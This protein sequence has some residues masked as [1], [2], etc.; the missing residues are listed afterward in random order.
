MNCDFYKDPRFLKMNKYFIFYFILNVI[1]MPKIEKYI[2]FLNIEFTIIT[3]QI[4]DNFIL[5]Y[6]F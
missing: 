3:E 6:E 4:K 1:A 5:L 2:L